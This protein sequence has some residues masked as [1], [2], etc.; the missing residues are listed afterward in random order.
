MFV[1]M[2]AKVPT[3][4]G[5]PSTVPIPQLG[6]ATYPSIRLS[7]WIVN[8]PGDHSLMTLFSTPLLGSVAAELDDKLAAKAAKAAA[9]ASADADANDDKGAMPPPPPKTPSKRASRGNGGAVSKSPP[10]AGVKSCGACRWLE[11]A[12]TV[13]DKG[14]AMASEC[15]GLTPYDDL[16]VRAAHWQNALEF[17][18]AG[19]A[20]ANSCLFLHVFALT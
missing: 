20:F 12:A 17:C 11:D 19:Q 3:R 7:P 9:E 6:N 8:K 15:G 14:V 13:L 5:R 18:L 16:R 2:L 4:R 10:L 1:D